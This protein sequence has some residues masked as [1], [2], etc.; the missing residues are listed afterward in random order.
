MRRVLI[1]T[2]AWAPQVN[3][4]VRTLQA[5][6]AELERQGHAV[7]F[8][9]P[10][11]HSTI[12]CPTYPE[13]RLALFPRQRVKR[14]IEAFDPDALH[15]ATEGP[16]GWAARS[17]A[18]ETGRSFTTAYHT[19]FPEYVQ[20]RTGLPVSVSSAVLRHFHRPSKGVMVPSKTI[21]QELADRGFQNLRHWTRGVDT[22][23]FRPIPVKRP[24]RPVFLYVGRVAVEKNIEAFLRLALPG[25]KWVVGDGPQMAEL[26]RKYPEVQW[27]GVRKGEPL[28]EAYNQASVFVFPS[29]TDTF[30]LVMA[31]A[32]ACGTPVAAFPVAGPVDV[33][34]PSAGVLSENLE[35]ASIR[36]LSCSR[37]E[38]LAWAAQYT[39]PEATRQFSSYLVPATP[40][41]ARVHAD[42]TQTS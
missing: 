14:E 36:A 41:K 28:A 33:V 16:L 4:V 21:I 24:E 7:R 37:D 12:P 42:L 25:E 18:L 40:S 5:T 15:I 20:A 8:L 34:G 3:G 31:E 26:Q 35:D 17:V 2:D 19:R 27:K 23:L 32:M 13:I 30:G 11:G 29:R 1:V 9:T 39:W 6:G 22:T 10:D 38:V